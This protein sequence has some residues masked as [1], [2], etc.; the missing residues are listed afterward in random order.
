MPLAEDGDPAAAISIK[1][2][3]WLTSLDKFL[4]VQFLLNADFDTLQ[5]EAN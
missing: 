4:I 3:I 1:N 5:N 2:R